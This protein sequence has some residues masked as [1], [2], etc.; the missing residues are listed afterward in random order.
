M[1]YLIKCSKNCEI[2]KYESLSLT[3]SQALDVPDGRR[4]P[5]PPQQRSSRSRGIDT[6]TPSVPGRSSSCSSL[7]P[8]PSPACPPR[9]HDGSPYSTDE[10]LDDR[11]KGQTRTLEAKTDCSI[12]S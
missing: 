8:C 1:L 10:M 5:F 2:V 3:V 7:S 9:S 6:Q 12:I 4:A 11:D